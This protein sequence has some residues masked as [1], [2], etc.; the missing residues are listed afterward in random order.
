MFAMEKSSYNDN[1]TLVFGGN[2]KYKMKQIVFGLENMGIR[3][4]V[5]QK[6]NL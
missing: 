1:V 3:T 2:G 5:F 6:T 4:A